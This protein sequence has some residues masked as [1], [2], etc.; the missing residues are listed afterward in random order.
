MDGQDLYR[1]IKQLYWWATQNGYGAAAE[2]LHLA[3]NQI[4]GENV[5]RRDQFSQLLSRLHTFDDTTKG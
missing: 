4:E 3:L 1:E 5:W 2:H